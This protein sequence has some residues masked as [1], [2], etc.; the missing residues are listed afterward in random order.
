MDPSLDSWELPLMMRSLIILTM[1][2]ANE[3]KLQ[4]QK[5]TFRPP[6]SALLD[7]VVTEDGCAGPNTS[8]RFHLVP[9]VLM[10]A[11]QLGWPEGYRLVEPCSSRSDMSLAAYDLGDLQ[12]ISDSL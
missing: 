2:F 9:S 8:A 1:E 6:S 4:G 3:R 11:P 10:C 12:K 5:S 7:S